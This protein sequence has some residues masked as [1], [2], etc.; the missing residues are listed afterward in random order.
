MGGHISRRLSDGTT[1]IVGDFN[2]NNEGGMLNDFVVL[3]A[4]FSTWARENCGVTDAEALCALCNKES[5][6]LTD[7]V[8]QNYDTLQKSCFDKIK[9]SGLQ[10][11]IFTN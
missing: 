6:S 10:I 1:S 7:T 2:H 4:K 8:K 3:G 5:L 11:P 9:A